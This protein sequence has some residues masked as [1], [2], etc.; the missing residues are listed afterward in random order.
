MTRITFVA[1]ANCLV[2]LMDILILEWTLMCVSLSVSQLAFRKFGTRAEGSKVK[3][4]R[5]FFRG[6]VV[7]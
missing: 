6:G 7:T 5:F 1:V 3:I 4:S 2:P